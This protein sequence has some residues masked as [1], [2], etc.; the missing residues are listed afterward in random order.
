MRPAPAAPGVSRF[1]EPAPSHGLVLARDARVLLCCVACGAS[2]TAECAEILP[3][4]GLNAGLATCPACR[5][6]HAAHEDT[7]LSDGPAI[8]LSDRA[9]MAACVHCGTVGDVW[10]WLDL[11]LAS[12]VV[13][14]R[15][16]A[17][18]DGPEH[19]YQRVCWTA[20]DGDLPTCAACFGIGTE[21]HRLH[22]AAESWTALRGM[23]DTSAVL[24]FETTG[25]L[26]RAIVEVGLVFPDKPGQPPRRYTSLVNPGEGVTWEP[27]EPGN[28][29]TPA[30]LADA[31]AWPGVHA[32][33]GDLLRYANV[34]AVLSWSYF[35]AAVLFFEQ[36]RITGGPASRAV[37]VWPVEALI[38][39]MA[40]YLRLTNADTF[41]RP[42]TVRRRVS[43]SD[44]SAAHGLPPSEH[45]A[46]SDAQRVVTILHAAGGALTDRIAAR[47][48]AR[49]TATEYLRA[50]WSTAAGDALV[51]PAWR[52]VDGVVRPVY[53]QPVE[54]G[55]DPAPP[56]S[57]RYVWVTESVM[58]SPG[59]VRSCSSCVLLSE[60]LAMLP[61]EEAALVD[62]LRWAPART[63]TPT[64]I[65]YTVNSAGTWA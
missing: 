12:G 28:G 14:P 59:E 54:R 9:Q 33:I 55:P 8:I 52:C 43:L 47:K 5:F 16:R 27:W 15:Y 56:G 48:L 6:V 65:A 60:L 62:R 39:A 19:D 26:S 18:R 37:G 3:D 31:P 30:E 4:D 38:D 41:R 58:T 10:R 32:T 35:E 25:L 40:V 64:R 51:R 63:E 22:D 50:T 46:L 42:G 36:D 49:R 44:A 2:W 13:G 20:T 34:R 45:R 57:Y 61:D 7:G 23:L 11:A 17:T 21:A 29:I 53:I 1:G 24:D